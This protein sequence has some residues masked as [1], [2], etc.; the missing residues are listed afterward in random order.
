MPTGS[1][2]V[3]PP[4]GAVGVG[5]SE[6]IHQA[7]SLDQDVS[8]A[9]PLGL[10]FFLALTFRVLVLVLG[11]G[12]DT[13]SVGTETAQA[14]QALAHHWLEHGGFASA[15]EDKTPLTADV[16]R[17]RQALGQ[18]PGANEAGL[19]PETYHLPGYSLILAGVGFVGLP[20]W[21]L[22][23]LQV[24][25][26]AATAALGFRLT[27][28]LF[29]KANVTPWIAGLLLAVHPALLVAAVALS[30]EVW[31]LFL[32]MLSLTGLAAAKD[33][34]TPGAFLSGVPFGVAML[35]HTLAWPIA[36]AMAIWPMLHHR[37]L[38]ALP[39]GLAFLVGSVLAPAVWLA[40]NAEL[41][42]GLRLSTETTVQ[43]YF[44]DVR[45]ARFYDP[46]QTAARKPA[47]ER[48]QLV[49]TWFDAS[50][51]STNAYRTLSYLTRQSF[52]EQPALHAAAVGRRVMHTTTREQTASLMQAV[53][54][55]PDQLGPTR[56]L[57]TFNA[58]AVG[59]ADLALH[60]LATGW[61]G[62]NL[63]LLTAAGIGL[64]M[65]LIHRQ[66]A[67]ALLLAGLW[68]FFAYSTFPAAGDLGL[69]LLCCQIVLGASILAP[70]PA[71]A[72][73]AKRVKNKRTKSTDPAEFDLYGRPTKHY[74]DDN[75]VDEEL[76]AEDP[77]PEEKWQPVDYEA[78][79]PSAGTTIGRPI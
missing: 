1:A 59:E 62:V 10:I 36:I 4:T 37:R 44:T 30:P 12:A 63:M 66:Y 34:G 61:I 23:L 74:S 28:H 32:L 52:W 7:D 57:K 22:Q 33:K 69:G 15:A 35:M 43:R 8:L 11:A 51:P 76:Q 77:K 14:H 21:T 78:P 54:I 50:D 58:P 53:G 13:A 24:L 25:L 75:G 20:L 68:G 16:E 45:E 17:V 46:S 3:A 2:S 41:N 65:M 42:T 48:Q 70:R 26:G 79:L 39:L 27:L 60:R 56:D 19:H 71:R 9:F 55:P 72:P 67:Q 38:Y 40:R 6:H 18:L 64:L 29:P 49:Q 31:F 5:A 47:G 73:K